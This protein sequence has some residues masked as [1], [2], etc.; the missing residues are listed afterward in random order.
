LIEE[1][2][3]ENRV[4]IN[5][6]VKERGIWRDIPPLIVDSSDPSEVERVAEKYMWKLFS[7]CVGEF[8]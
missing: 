2:S 1:T 6:K 4:H 5:F 8:I 3:E 7:A